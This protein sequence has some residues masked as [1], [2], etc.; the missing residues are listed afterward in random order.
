MHSKKQQVDSSKHSKKNMESEAK[1]DLVY[2]L[3]KG[4]RWNNNE[5]RYSLRSAQKNLKNFGKVFVVGECPP[6]L[7]KVIHIPAQDRY[8]HK[9]MNATGKIR[10]ACADKRVSERF[11][12]MNDDFFFVHPVSKIKLFSRGT[13]REHAGKHPT[14]AGYYY[15]A[16][17]DT[18]KLLQTAG[19]DEPA[20]FEVHY[21]IEFEKE[22]FIAVTNQIAWE[23]IGYLFRS[24]Y[25]NTF[26]EK[27]EVRKDVKAYGANELEYL[28]TNE[29]IS[30]SDRCALHR[31]FQEWI[32]NKFPTPSK[33][34]ADKIVE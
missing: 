32:R 33:Y 13:I 20:D 29:V 4:S 9:L 21:P 6:W 19:I 17:T 27:Y 26:P 25:Y 7:T 31:K 10:K 16:L 8:G 18:L 34:E 11:I 2:I 1:R 5:I 12:L 3:G 28:K 14:R 22:K 24:V 15:E 23:R 30:I